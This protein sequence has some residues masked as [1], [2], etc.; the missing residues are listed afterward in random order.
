[1]GLIDHARFNALVQLP[2]KETARK[3]GYDAALYESGNDG[4][5]ISDFGEKARK[6]F[7]SG[8]IS[9]GHYYELMNM[10]YGDE[11]EKN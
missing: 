1:M 9:E 4:V 10:L 2:I 11:G 8:K 5:V 7:E 3:W 6:L